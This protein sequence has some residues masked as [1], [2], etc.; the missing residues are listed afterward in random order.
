MG[1]NAFLR[2]LG[3]ISQATEAAGTAIFQKI[4]PVAGARAC[5]QRLSVLTLATAHVLTVMKNSAKVF[6]SAE[7]AAAQKVLNITED[8]GSIATNDYCIIKLADG[9]Y[10]MNMV[11]SVSTLAIT[12]TDNFTAIVESGA[13]V[14]FFGVVGDSHPQ[15]TL[16]A[17]AENEFE[18]PYGYFVAA[19]KGV[20]L[21]LSID[22]GTNASVLQGGVVAYINA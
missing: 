8:P 22:N 1:Y 11:A 19:D 6:A 13:P 21:I 16:A 4:D 12:F 2:K 17:N 3:D 18:S 5:I 14:W 15:Y 20:P 10:Q 7:A 9:T